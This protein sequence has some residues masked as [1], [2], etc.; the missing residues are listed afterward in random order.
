MFALIVASQERL[1]EIE[2]LQMQSTD[3]L[4]RWQTIEEQLDLESKIRS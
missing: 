4:E 3:A 2:E 1:A